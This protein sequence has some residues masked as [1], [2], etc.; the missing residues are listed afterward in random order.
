MIFL[1]RITRAGYN[2]DERYVASP[3][4]EKRLK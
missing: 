1:D 2:L 3:S 4:D